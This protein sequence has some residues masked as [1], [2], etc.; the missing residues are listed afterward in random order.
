MKT[1]GDQGGA[2]RCI[3]CSYE[4]PPKSFFASGHFDFDSIHLESAYLTLGT[5]SNQNFSWKAIT[6]RCLS[7]NH[8]SLT[9]RPGYFEQPWDPWQ[10]Q[11]RPPRTNFVHHLSPPLKSISISVVRIRPWGR[12]SLRPAFW[13]RP[14]L[15][16]YNGPASKSVHEMRGKSRNFRRSSIWTIGPSADG[17]PRPKRR[18]S[19]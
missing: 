19:K 12:P 5:E 4:K 9:R 10:F 16:K 11:N 8:F 13:I 3:I 2:K 1:G 18:V 17:H 14:H 15:D 6:I 7:Y